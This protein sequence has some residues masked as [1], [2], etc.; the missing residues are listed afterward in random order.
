MVE[1]GKVS[2]ADVEKAFQSMSGEGGKFENLMDKQSKTVAGAWSN[3]KDTITKSAEAMG[4][5]LMPALAGVITSMTKMTQSISDTITGANNFTFGIGELKKA[6]AEN[7][8]EQEDLQKAY[9]NGQVSMV[10]YNRKMDTLKAS[11]ESL[12]S[13][14]EDVKWSLEDINTALSEL[15]RSKL[16]T[17]QKVQELRKIQIQA[18][19]S[20]YALDNLIKKLEDTRLGLSKKVAEEKKQTET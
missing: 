12:K 3:F 4:I 18:Q 7:K 8:Q 2:F 1:Q 5:Q 15:E 19:E 20:A 13:Q 6:M 9:E 10:D 11:E 16:S 14:S 17:D